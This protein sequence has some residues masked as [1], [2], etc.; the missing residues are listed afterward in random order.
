VILTPYTSQPPAGTEPSDLARDLRVGALRLPTP[1]GE[2]WADSVG[3]LRV[4]GGTGSLI[5]RAGRDG[6]ERASTSGAAW[7]DYLQDRGA[8]DPRDGYAWVMRA[9]LVSSLANWG[10]LISRT[11]DNGTTSGWSWQRTNG[12]VVAAYHGVSGNWP[13]GITFSTL[14]DGQPHTLVGV[15]RKDQSRLELW[16]DGILLAA[17]N[18][19]STAPGYSAGQ[20]QV[21]IMSSR[22]VAA[23]NG[24]VALVA[25]LGMAPSPSEASALSANPWLLFEPPGVEVAFGVEVETG[26]G[27]RELSGS[28][29]VSVQASGTLTRIPAEV[30]AEEDDEAYPGALFGF[31]PTLGGE[32]ILPPDTAPG[33]TLTPGAGSIHVEW[34]TA[35]T[36][37]MTHEVEIRRAAP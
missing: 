31:L 26:P 25:V 17:V 2:G 15:W 21:K 34:D 36:Q 32:I 35:I 28:A 19:V 10:G 7:A 4:T 12:D 14:L 5:T 3:G 20:G 33:I 16:R 30:E 22:D 37:Y 24:S 1:G 11:T 23:L 18:G 6:Y 13:L 29:A 9:T 8:H 27:L